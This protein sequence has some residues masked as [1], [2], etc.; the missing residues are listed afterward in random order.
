MTGQSKENIIYGNLLVKECFFYSFC[1]S[2]CL[3]NSQIVFLCFD[4]WHI[5]PKWVS[6]L[7]LRTDE[8]RHQ[9]IQDISRSG[10]WKIRE[11][12]IVSVEGL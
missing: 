2:P 5:V 9:F 10:L 8:L 1:L 4:T 3:F 6:D 7:L 12:N 11:L